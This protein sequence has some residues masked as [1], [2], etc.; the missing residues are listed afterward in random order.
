MESF[1]LRS[2]A[3][4]CFFIFANAALAQAPTVTLTGE[5]TPPVITGNCNGAD[6]SIAFT[7]SVYMQVS[8]LNSIVG[9]DWM[10]QW[11]AAWTFGTD[12]TGM[13]FL[14]APAP[15]NNPASPALP[16]N[17]AAVTLDPASNTF[18]F[19]IPSASTSAWGQ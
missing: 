18:T 10:T 5:F 17:V 6:G 12:D 13:E 19:N 3:A 16:S 8:E 1:G 2:A 15:V 4:G 14:S 7:T 9:G 11:G